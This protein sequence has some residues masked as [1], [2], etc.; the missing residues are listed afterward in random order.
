MT[1]GESAYGGEG[2]LGTAALPAGELREGARTQLAAHLVEFVEVDL[3]VVAL[4]GQGA[5]DLALQQNGQKTEW[6]THHRT[7]NAHAHTH[8]VRWGF[9]VVVVPRKA[10]ALVGIVL[11]LVQYGAERGDGYAFRSESVEKKKNVA[12][13]PKLR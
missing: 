7:R 2:Q 3:Q 10:N 6:N 12:G 13:P 11:E 1:K 8:T 5:V 9:Q 4:H